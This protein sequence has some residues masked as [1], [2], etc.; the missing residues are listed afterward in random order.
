MRQAAGP[1][2]AHGLSP[3]NNLSNHSDD[4]RVI[5]VAFFKSPKTSVRWRFD[6]REKRPIMEMWVGARS[7]ELIVYVFFMPPRGSSVDQCPLCLPIADICGPTT[8]EPSAPALI[9]IWRAGIC[10]AL[11][12]MS[13]PCFGCKTNRMSKIICQMACQQGRN[14]APAR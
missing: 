4:H 14:E 11:R 1:D 5:C 7:A 8:T 10:I 12:T 3:R 6:F 9:A 13:T 2:E